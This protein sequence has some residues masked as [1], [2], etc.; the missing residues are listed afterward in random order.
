MRNRKNTEAQTF[1]AFCRQWGI[2]PSEI[3]LLSEEDPYFEEQEE[4]DY[5][6]PADKRSEWI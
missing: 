2:L 1:Y 6:S 3:A 5:E 4:F